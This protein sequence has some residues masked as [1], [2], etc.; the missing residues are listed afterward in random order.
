LGIITILIL[1]RRFI[2]ER[3]I[4]IYVVTAIVVFAV[5]QS[6]F[7]VSHY[8]IGAFGKDP[9]LTG[10]TD[11]WKHLLEF[12]TN[13]LIGVGFESFW[14]GERLGQLQGVFFFI[15]NEAHNG[16]LETYLNMGSVGV[17]VLAGVL[18]STFFKICSEFQRN[19]DWAQYR[20]AFFAAVLLYNWT[21]SA[22]RSLHPVWFGFYLI[23]M[24]YSGA[25]FF[26]GQANSLRAN[27]QFEPAFVTS[28]ADDCSVTS[29][30]IQTP[31]L[32]Q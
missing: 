19:L 26:F 21:E 16:Y 25:D 13:P 31:S 28:T 24:E 1:Q 30:A 10:R 12:H 5:A 27:G 29:G 6:L 9:T 17:L 14:L 20:L 8:V 22:F 7:A 11:L 15:P 2:D 32:F 3:L 23:A 18:V 4:A